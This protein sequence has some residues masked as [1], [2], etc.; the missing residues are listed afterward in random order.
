MLDSPPKAGAPDPHVL[1]L[2]TPVTVRSVR[3]VGAVH[4]SPSL[5]YH[6]ANEAFNLPESNDTPS[7]T[8]TPLVDVIL[9]AQ[10]EARRL[11]RLGAFGD[12]SVTLDSVPRNRKQKNKKG[13]TPVDLV[14]EVKEKSRIY[15]RTGTDLGSQEGSLNASF[16]IRNVFGKAETIETTASLGMQT[17][18]SLF[19]SSTPVPQSQPFASQSSSVF[20]VVYNQPIDADPDR[21]VELSAF[22]TDRSHLV[23]SSFQE[24][25]QGLSA[26][27]LISRTR[28]GDHELKW[29]GEWRQN[30]G[31]SPTASWSI[32]NEAGHSLKSALSHTW[33]RDTRDDVALPTRGSYLK[34]LQE[35]SGIGGDTNHLKWDLWHQ[36]AFDLGRG[37][38]LNASVRGGTIVPLPHT[39]LNGT[40]Q[41]HPR[42][43][44]NDRF[45][46]G[47][48][49]SVRGFLQNGVGPRDGRDSVGA[50]TYW[51][52]GLSL[53]TPLP[54][55]DLTTPLKGHLFLNAGAGRM[56]G[57]GES[58]KEHLQALV[59]TPA[60]V[61]CGVGLALRLSMFRVEVNYCVPVLA[62]SN[63]QYRKGVNL[64]IGFQFL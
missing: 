53:L 43:R 4:S 51:S 21:R 27:Y 49:T 31:L 42:S 59:E 48:P 35:W 8:T 52:A 7:P 17:H 54:C 29:N 9:T 55:V 47:G 16:N 1:D 28:L 39:V 14:F 23:F 64:G 18:F 62:L 33:V 40:T 3:V 38:L 20:N 50:D 15:A 36:S 41:V 44:V 45:F 6:A 10:S 2:D 61:S 5:F 19:P 57:I 25:S 32:R 26:K 13:P 11:L 58:S 30:H 34:L 37:F 46:L 63:D 22:K 12:V 24:R 60:S 56:R